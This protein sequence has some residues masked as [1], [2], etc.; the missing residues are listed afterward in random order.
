MVGSQRGSCELASA[1]AAA[2]QWQIARAVFCLCRKT[3]EN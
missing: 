1:A 3:H 2:V